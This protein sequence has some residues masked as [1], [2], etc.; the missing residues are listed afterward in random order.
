MAQIQFWWE[1]V[2]HFP[3]WRGEYF[4]NVA[5]VGAPELIRNDAAV[6]FDWGRSAPAPGLP[7]DGF[8]ARWTRVLAFEG[9]RYRFRAIVDD[10]V[11]LYVDDRRVIDA[12]QDGARRE[13]MADYALSPGNHSLRIEYYE[14]AGEARIQVWWEKV[15]NYPDWKGEYWSNRGLSGSPVLARNDVSVDFNWG[16]GSPAAAVPSDNF[17]VR[18]TRQAGFDAATYRFHVI[19]DDGARLWV[20]DQLILDAWQDGAVREVTADYALA[21]GTHNLRVEFYEHT[22]E[23]R[24]RVW[25]E[26]VSHPAYPDWKGEYWS[27]RGL[28]GSPVLVRNDVSVDFNWGWD[29]PTAAVPSDNFSVRW[30]R[31]ARFD[32]ATYRF[33]VIVDD[34]AR[35]WV[36]DQLIL[37]AWQD[38][39][40]REVATDY[41]LA[42]GTHSLRVE[43]YEHTREARIHVWWEKISRPAYPDWK[44]EYWSNRSLS[45]SRALVRN[46]EMIDFHWNT[47]AAAT[48]LPANNFSARWSRQVSFG[49]GGIYRFYAWAD[50]GIRVYVDGDLVLDEWHDSRGDDVYVVD[51]TLAGRHE[52]TVEYYERGGDALVKFWWKRIGDLPTPVPTA[53]KPAPPTPAPPTATPEP[54]LPPTPTPE[55][56]LTPTPTPEPTPE[57]IGVRLNEI[58]PAP[59]AV[60]W[61]RDGTADELD[62][63]IELYNAGPIAVDLGGWLLDSSESNAARDNM[64]YVIPEGTILWPGE[65]LIFYRQQTGILL[66]DEGGELRLRI[67]SGMLVETVTF[68]QLAADASY[69]RDDGGEWHTDWPPSPGSTNLPIALAGALEHSPKPR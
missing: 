18:W 56:T 66:Q 9:G 20:D 17:S 1:R 16:W 26:K 43:F 64:P 35:L 41:A 32:A 57:R 30:T 58:L 53:T 55:P 5:L 23:A 60:D 10:G 68:G 2:G 19:V 37:D 59:A 34:G 49:S 63:W 24:I 21:R 25:W 46:D 45:G 29:S 3:Q 14:H 44:G 4:S 62:E 48:G 27:N 12:W 47:G 39:A 65:F 33:H 54:T 38:G 6:D 40:A 13:V 8:S 11:R 67:P 42:R 15:A 28:S 36:D 69:S 7:S 52:L 22:R 50:D 31:Q 61:G 51:L